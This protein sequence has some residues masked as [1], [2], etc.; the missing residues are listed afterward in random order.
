MKVIKI[1]D[2]GF[3][4]QLSNHVGNKIDGDP[5]WTARFLATNPDAVYKT[6]LDFLKAGAD[7]IET[8]TY[9]ASTSGLM[10]H[11]NINVEESIDLLHKAVTLAKNAVEEFKKNHSL[12]IPLIAGSCGPYGASLNNFSEYTGTYGKDVPCEVLMDWHRPRL[13]ALV[14]AGVDLIALET[15]PCAEE[16]EA[17]MKLLRE[18]PNT[19]AWI[20]FSCQ[21]N[22]LNLSDGN[23]FAKIAT[24]C[25]STAIPKQVIA[26]GV[27]C[28]APANVTA[29]LTSINGNKSIDESIPLIAYPNSG[30]KYSP[31]EGWIENK[32]PTSLECYISEWVKLGINI[33]GGCCRW[34]ADDINK[35]RQDVDKFTKSQS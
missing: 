31:S 25:Y 11:F 10:K 6:H 21:P 19:K 34:N 24:R 17:L 30:E 27:N 28:I 20:S 32:N 29:L 35:L 12:R 14:N 5:L 8:N 18:F 16:A 23:D 2:G 1:L 26:V 15:I 9:Q 3:S 33:I 13:R 22:S 7:I 4:T